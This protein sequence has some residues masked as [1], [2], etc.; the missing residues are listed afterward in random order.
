MCVKHETYVR[1]QLYFESAA[2]VFVAEKRKK[3]VKKKKKK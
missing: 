3:K 1:F 2:R